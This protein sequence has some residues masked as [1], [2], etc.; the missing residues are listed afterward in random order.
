[1]L[2]TMA[3][4]YQ[5][6]S[7]TRR[8]RAWQ[9]Y[10]QGWFGWLF[11]TSRCFAFLVGRPAARSAS[12]PVWITWWC[13]ACCVQQRV[14]CVSKCRKLRFFLRLHHCHDAEA[15]SHVPDCLV[16]HRDSPLALGHGDRGPCC[17]TC[18]CCFCT[19]GSHLESGHFFTALDLAVLVRYSSPEQYKNMDFSGDDFQKMFPYSSYALVRS[20]Y[21]YMRQST[22]A[23]GRI[24]HTSY[25]QVDSGP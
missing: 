18:S 17:G 16:D 5:K 12:W 21:K 24:S 11:C 9:W 7:S 6:D 2:G 22:V 19:R 14:P 25:V 20:G 1:M 4:M 23:P 3:G 10:V 13:C 15:V 8:R